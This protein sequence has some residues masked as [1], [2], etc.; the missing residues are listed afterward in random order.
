MRKWTLFLL[1]GLLLVYLFMTR[2]GANDTLSPTPTCKSGSTFDGK[3]CLDSKRIVSTPTCPSGYYFDVDKCVLGTR[4]PSD[5]TRYS[6]VISGIQDRNVGPLPTAI[7][8][9]SSTGD[10]D[11]DRPTSGSVFGAGGPFSRRLASG[12]GTGMNAA[13][14]LTGN[15]Y[16]GGTVQAPGSTGTASN[17]Y[18]LQTGT[19]GS[20]APPG[21]TMPVK[22]PQWGGP[23]TST[24]AS[25]ASSSRAAPAIYGPGGGN[26]SGGSDGR[27]SMDFGTLEFGMGG[28]QKTSMD[29]SMLPSGE[30]AGSEPSNRYAV[31]SRAPG[32]QD[33]YAS[34]YTQS[35]SYSLANGS[36]K[37]EPVPYLTDFSA[38]QN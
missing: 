15:S 5:P 12:Q 17:Q 30:S 33:M 29:V 31:T 23:G 10:T 38:F 11:I 37:T 24:I 21:R 13:A 14:A 6:D 2:E 22:G 36:Q 20:S 28:S 25:S 26:K 7:D 16:G 27:G 3:N 32:D 19:K 34:P 1:V 8:E 35:T 18:D 9:R 4:P